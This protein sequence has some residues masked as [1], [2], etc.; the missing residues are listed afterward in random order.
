VILLTIIL[1]ILEMPKTDQQTQR[2]KDKLLNCLKETSGIVAYAC[3]RAGISRTTYYYWYDD[4]DSFRERADDIKE[5]QID[6]AEAAL[7]KKIKAEDTTAIIFYLKTQGRDRGY[8]ERREITGVNGDPIKIGNFDI[9][10]LPTE[11]RSMLLKIAEKL[12]ET[13]GT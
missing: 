12:N 3:E 1:N 4:D 13:K 2:D 5:L 7:L 6:V 9:A 10:Q 11:T 8:T